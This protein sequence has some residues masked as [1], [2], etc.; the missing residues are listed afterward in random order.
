MSDPHRFHFA[1]FAPVCR[2]QIPEI[3]FF[4]MCARAPTICLTADML[5]LSFTA[6]GDKIQQVQSQVA[7]AP[8]EHIPEYLPFHPKTRSGHVRIGTQF[9]LCVVAILFCQKTKQE[10]WELEK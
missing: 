1:P 5:F 10:R 3:S 8:P 7:Q 2:S 4:A 9:T 6:T